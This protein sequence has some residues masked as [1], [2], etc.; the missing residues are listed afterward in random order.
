[1]T[2][3]QMIETNAGEVMHLFEVMKNHGVTCSLELIR[4]KGNDPFIGISGV[5]VDVEYLEGDEGDTLV[6][7]MG[8]TEFGFGLGDHVFGKLIS[9]CQIMVSILEKDG[10]YAVWF[11]SDVVSPEGIEEANGYDDT[12]GNDTLYDPIFSEAEK[13]LIYFIRTLEFDD[14]LDAVSGIEREAEDSKQKAALN[15]RE[16]NH[17]TANG[18]DKRVA[19]LSK[20]AELLGKANIDYVAHIYP[21]AGE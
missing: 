17:R 10:E 5:N 15:F 8:E 18:F 2:N 9:D 16:G 13:E 3:T 11:D 12:T 6:V 7:K 14:V 20:L 1:M 21:D 19:N 4:A